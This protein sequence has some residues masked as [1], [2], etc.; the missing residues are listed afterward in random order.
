MDRIGCVVLIVAP[1][2]SD[3]PCLDDQINGALAY[4]VADVIFAT[5]L[6]DA[7]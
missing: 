5:P 4:S 6:G 7:I 3:V 1:T 2:S